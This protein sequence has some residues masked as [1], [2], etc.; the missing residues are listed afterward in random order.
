M[1]YSVIETRVHL[2][3]PASAW[4]DQEVLYEV[5]LEVELRSWEPIDERLGASVFQSQ[6]WEEINR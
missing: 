4:L 1:W 3:S 5:T 6:V 2:R